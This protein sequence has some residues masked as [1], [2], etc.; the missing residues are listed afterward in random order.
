MYSEIR[1]DSKSNI[2]G[3][4]VYL[5]KKILYKCNDKAY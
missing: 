2:F 1:P 4:G 3:V 5:A